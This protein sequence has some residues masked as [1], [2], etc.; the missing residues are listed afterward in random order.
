MIFLIPALFILPHFLGL[1]GVWL[2][3]PLADLLS[4]ILTMGV[5]LY[6]YRKMKMG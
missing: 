2:A 6:Y 3:C 5:L 1:D 4:F